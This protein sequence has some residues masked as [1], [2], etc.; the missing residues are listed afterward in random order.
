MT[1]PKIS[2]WSAVDTLTNTSIK[3]AVCDLCMIPLEHSTW[4]GHKVF[5][6]KSMS[7][8]D[9]FLCVKCATNPRRYAKKKV[10]IQDLDDYIQK[11]FSQIFKI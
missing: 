11:K 5:Y 8:F 2:G 6:S 4:K 9:G 10:T 3:K 7:H 1:R